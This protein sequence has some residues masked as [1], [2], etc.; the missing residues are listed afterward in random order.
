MPASQSRASAPGFVSSGGTP[1]GQH[2][3]VVCDAHRRRHWDAGAAAARL[4]RRA[5]ALR[6][7]EAAAAC[8]RSRSGL[9]RAA[10]TPA[11]YRGLPGCRWGLDARRVG[12]R[13]CTDCAERVERGEGG[14]NTSG[15]GWL[16]E[17]APSRLLRRGLGLRSGPW[18]PS[19]TVACSGRPAFPR[20]WPP[21]MLTLR[22]KREVPMPEA[23]TRRLAAQSSPACVGRAAGVDCEGASS[24]SPSCSRGS[25]RGW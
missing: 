21:D 3:Y 18:L 9:C 13:P 17:A 19:S 22:W 6:G 4:L 2:L 23:V 25:S 8:S 20:P 15:A 5:V 16:R 12:L 24:R 7:G 14:S 10:S 11:L 1:S